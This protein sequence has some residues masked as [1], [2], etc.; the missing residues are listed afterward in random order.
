MLVSIGYR[1]CHWCHVMERESFEDPET[2]EL[3]NERFVCVKVD[4]EERPD[5]DAIYMRGAGDRRSRRLAAQRLP[6]ARPEAVL[7]RHVLA[8][9]ADGHGMPSWRQVLARRRQRVDDP[10][11]SGWTLRATKSRKRWAGGGATEA[12]ERRST[13]RPSKRGGALQASFDARW[14]GWGRARSS[15]RPSRD[16][17]AAARATT[18]D[19]AGNAAARWPRR[20]LRPGRAAASPA[21]A[22]THAWTGAALR[23][24]ALR[25]RTACARLPARLAGQRATSAAAQSRRRRSTSSLRELRGPEGGFYSAPST[26]TERRGVEG[27][28][29]A[30][31]LDELRDELDG[32]TAEP[33]RT[34]LEA[35]VAW[36][37]ATQRGDFE[38]AN[39]LEARGPEPPAEQRE[40]IR[41]TLLQARSR[42]VRRAGRRT[43]A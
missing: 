36:S 26:P 4:R 5:V 30:W 6:D 13:P 12:V 34:D 15:R 3:M 35:A 23:E 17:A 14:G 39:V 25:Q 16:R 19:G 40:R 37:G 27:K 1:A 2:A 28:F 33:G 43:S 8:T 24:D 41:A 32:H 21:T 38:G 31:T 20:D 10:A 11:R 29:Y 18:R 7:R 22:S 42:R 9:G